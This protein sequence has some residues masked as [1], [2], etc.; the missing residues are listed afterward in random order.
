MSKKSGLRRQGEQATGEPLVME[1]EEGEPRAPVTHQK[2]RRFGLGLIFLKIKTT[3]NDVV[4]GFFLK[5]NHNTPSFWA[6]SNQ[7]NTV[8]C[9]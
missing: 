1:E 3:Q 9:V 4:L 5:K 8:L 6:P 2:R 7:N